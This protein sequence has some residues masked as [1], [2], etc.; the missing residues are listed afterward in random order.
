MT[1]NSLRNLEFLQKTVKKRQKMSSTPVENV[2]QISFFMQNKP[3]FPHFSTQN[4]D[5]TQK[6][7]QFKPNS[8]P[9]LRQKSWSKPNQTQ[10]VNLSSIGA[11]L[12][13]CRGP[14]SN[15]NKKFTTLKG[16]SSDKQ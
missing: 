5:L 6:Q 14:I 1:T 8:K 11:H 16:V 4:D 12:L 13:P 3:N 7:T 10:F 15:I 9:I 2:R